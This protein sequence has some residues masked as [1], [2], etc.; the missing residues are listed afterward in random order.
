MG[1]GTLVMYMC[2]IYLYLS[3]SEQYY[4]H[5]TQSTI[6]KIKMCRRQD[7]GGG[8]SGGGKGI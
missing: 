1:P 6:T 2:G 7:G 5:G 3:Q 8:G 4:K